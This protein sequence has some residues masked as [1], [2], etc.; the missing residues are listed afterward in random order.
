MTILY[1]SKCDF[2]LSFIALYEKYRRHSVTYAKF[3]L[4]TKEARALL[5]SRQINFV[6]LNTIYLVDEKVSIK[7][8]AVLKILWKTKWPVRLL[9][10]L[11]ILPVRFTDAVYEFVAKNRYRLSKMIVKYKIN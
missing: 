3:D 10:V 7:S 5:K 4:R 8:T 9:Y 2:C 6:N 11:H 1:D